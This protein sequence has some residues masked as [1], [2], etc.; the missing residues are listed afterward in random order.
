MSGWGG[1]LSFEVKGR[2]NAAHRVL[3]HLRL[4][5]TGASVGAAAS[6][7][8]LAAANMSHY[9]DCTDAAKTGV[10]PGLIRM[11]VGLEDSRDLI[12]DLEQALSS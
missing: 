8:V 7:V 10:A 9:M 12:A 3:D 6:L 4:P 1:V 5:R 2:L 11:S